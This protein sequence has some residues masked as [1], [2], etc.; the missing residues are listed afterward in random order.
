M[1]M[2]V[3]GHARQH[4][5]SQGPNNAVAPRPLAQ[6]RPGSRL[7]AGVPVQQ[8]AAFREGVCKS[9]HRAASQIEW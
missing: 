5:A 1:S 4:G 3:A 7:R 8:A 6:Q 9:P 2:N